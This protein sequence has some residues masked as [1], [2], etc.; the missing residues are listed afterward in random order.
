MKLL[1][2]DVSNFPT[3]IE[4]NY[5]YVDKTKIIYQF[6]K[7]RRLFFLSR[8]RRFGKTLLISTLK[9]LFSGNKKLFENTWI[10]SSDYKWIEYPIIKLD[11]S[12]LSFE[13]SQEFKNDLIWELNSIAKKYDISIA[14]APSLST[15]F[16][17]LI[18]QLSVKDKN[19]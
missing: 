17:F 2:I 1:P 11:F 10:G 8:P 3:I 15:K 6:L 4:N 12:S 16:K 7:D 5:I 14:D 18:Q 13:T 9:E 19:Q